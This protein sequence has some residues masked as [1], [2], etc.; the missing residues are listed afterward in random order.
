M[1]SESS[2]ALALAGARRNRGDYGRF[3][4]ERYRCI[5]LF[6][7]NAAGRIEYHDTMDLEVSRYT[8]DREL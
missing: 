7:A 8:L 4:L 5:M 2:G 3:L 6:Q 1:R